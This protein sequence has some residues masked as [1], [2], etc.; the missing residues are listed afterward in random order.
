MINI[1][2]STKIDRPADAVFDYVSEITNSPSWNMDVLEVTKTSEGPIGAGSAFHLRMKPAMGNS[3]ADLMI[4]EFKPKTV[5]IRA[6]RFGRMSS[7]HSSQFASDGDA[8]IYTEEIEVSMGGGLLGLLE[9]FFKG[10][11]RK[12]NTAVL[13][14]LKRNLEQG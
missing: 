1:S 8:T 10:M 6:I 3:E 11:V 13:E 2:I 4:T 14:N 5:L 9:P 7:T 12:R